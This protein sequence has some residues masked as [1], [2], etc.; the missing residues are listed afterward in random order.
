MKISIPI[1]SMI[2][3]YWWPMKAGDTCDV[4]I[5][6]PDASNR[7]LG[8][9][10]YCIGILDDDCCW[11]PIL[12]YSWYQ[13][14]T[15]EI[16]RYFDDLM[17]H[18]G[19]LLTIGLAT[20]HYSGVT[21]ASILLRWLCH[22]YRLKLYWSVIVTYTSLTCYRYVKKWSPTLYL[23]IPI[24]RVFQYRYRW[25]IPLFISKANIM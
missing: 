3:W 9:L 13:P 25:G 4:F 11:W 5:Y 24:P 19:G 21:E 1:P 15:D 8:I 16:F 22:Y 14:D 17:I 12:F 20:F 2:I 7:Y 23:L 6:I 10:P 18:Y